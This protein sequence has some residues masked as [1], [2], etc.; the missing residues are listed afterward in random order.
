MVLDKEYIAAA[1]HTPTPNESTPTPTPSSSPA[2][3]EAAT[4]RPLGP[5]E[6]E[7]DGVV[8]DKAVRGTSKDPRAMSDPQWI[9]R[10]SLT[11]N[12]LRINVHAEQGQF[13]KLQPGDRVQ[14][15]YREGKYTGTVWSSRID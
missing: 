13:E 15:T 14:V 1:E 10:V 8:M 6:I 12:R 3:E 4:P 9:V 11:S 2:D 5:N 7:V